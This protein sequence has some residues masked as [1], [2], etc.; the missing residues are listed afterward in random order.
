MN[1]HELADALAAIVGPA[2]VLHDDAGRARASADI[3]LWPEAQRVELVVAPA[4]SEEVAR[5]VA[6]LAQARR[7]LVPRGAGLSYTAGVVPSMPAIALD[8]RRLDRVEINADD[9]Y[10]IV[11]AGVTWDSLATRLRPLALRSAMSGPISGSHSTIGG[12]VSQNVPGSMDGVIGLAVVLADGTLARTGGAARGAPFWRHV[13]PDLTGLFLGDCGAFGVKTEIVLRLVPDRAA[14]FLSLGF[15]AADQLLATMV[16]LLHAGAIAR[17]FGLDKVKSEG[18]TKVDAGEGLRTV[19]AVMAQAGSVGQAL[20]D[21]A[22]MVRAGV[23]ARRDPP[24]SLHCTIEG[25]SPAA[26]QAECARAKEIC[27][28]QAVEIDNTLPKALRAKPFSIRG[29]VGPEGD[30]WVPIHGILPLGR[31]RAA[32]AALD[33][34]LAAEADALAT[35]GVH[36][37]WHFSS[38]GGAYIVIEPMFYWRDAL[39]A[40]QLEH[41]SERNRARFDGAPVNE[42]ARVL[43][44][45]LRRSLSDVIDAQGGV[46]AQIGRFYRHADLLEPGALALARRIKRAL[47]AEGTMNPGV[48]GLE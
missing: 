3:F 7:R 13:G 21:A 1:T 12:A 23:V 14:E 18:A 40:V 4:S 6:V 26:A 42:E 43:V 39:D 30:R 34:A 24:W 33:A 36:V 2:H 27:L 28:R 20:R 31:A 16:E 32:F 10:A 45:R 19:G 29:I 48:L 46:H 47:D 41:L 25:G 5:V 38:L 37:H 11:G 9:R 17:G 35:S 8:L 44:R 15:D 22:Q